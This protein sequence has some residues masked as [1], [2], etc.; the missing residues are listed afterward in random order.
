MPAPV[1][2]LSIS[3]A[4]AAKRRKAG[5]TYVDL[6]KAAGCTPATIKRRLD[7]RSVAAVAPKAVKAV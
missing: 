4:D 1:K 2:P 3:L 5:E 6:A 7:A